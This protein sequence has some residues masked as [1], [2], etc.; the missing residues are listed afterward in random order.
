ML[1]RRGNIAG[2]ELFFWSSFVEYIFV[3]VHTSSVALLGVCRLCSLP[4]RLYMKR[5]MF[6]P[7]GLCV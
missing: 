2:G 1:K 3:V 6:F 7:G 5:I 4:A